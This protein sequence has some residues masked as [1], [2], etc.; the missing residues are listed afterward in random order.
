[1]SIAPWWCGIIIATKSASTS[2]DG[3]IAI[4]VIILAIATSFSA[5]NG[6]SSRV[7]ARDAVPAT[8]ANASSVAPGKRSWRSLKCIVSHSDDWHEGRYD[9]DAAAREL[10]HR[11]YNPRAGIGL[12]IDG[13][14]VTAVTPAPN[15]ALVSR[16]RSNV[17]TAPCPHHRAGASFPGA[18]RFSAV[19][20]FR[21]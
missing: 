11:L 4:A 15:G 2:P 6:C 18:G 10:P 14:P 20:S 19:A 1:M 8:K 5:M 12:Q 7:A 13:Y 16:G 17:W 3:L 9:Q 21:C